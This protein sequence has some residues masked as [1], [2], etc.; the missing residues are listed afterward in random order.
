LFADPTAN[1]RNLPA[2]QLYSGDNYFGPVVP[3]DK[4]ALKSPPPQGFPT[5]PPNWEDTGS[6]KNKKLR[7]QI[8]LRELSQLVWG[9]ITDDPSQD[10]ATVERYPSPRPLVRLGVGKMP[11]SYWQRGLDSYA[12]IT[13]IVDGQIGRVLDALEDLPRDVRE[14][15]L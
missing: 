12:Q 5:L 14:N 1:P 3:W 15:R 4:N 6:L 2:S 8:F 9:G 13:S 7:T 11:F 10:T